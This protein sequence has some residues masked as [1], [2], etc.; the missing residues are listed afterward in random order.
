[1]SNP[2]APTERIVVKTKPI[3]FTEPINKSKV[4]VKTNPTATAEIP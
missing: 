4:A 3:F 2:K 1:M